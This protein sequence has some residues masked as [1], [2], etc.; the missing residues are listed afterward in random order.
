MRYDKICITIYPKPFAAQ[1]DALYLGGNPVEPAIPKRP[2]SRTTRGIVLL[3]GHTQPPSLSVP[4][5]RPSYLRLHP[6]AYT[7]HGAL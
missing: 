6:I 1:R 4:K 2:A 7:V 5:L 3:V